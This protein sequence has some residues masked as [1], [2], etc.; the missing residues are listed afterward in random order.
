ME[1]REQF[2]T[3][4]DVQQLKHISFSREQIAGLLRVIALYQHGVY[5]E[6]E[7]SHKDRG[8]SSGSTSRVVCKA[9]SRSPC[10]GI[11]AP[12]L[13]SYGCMDRPTT[14]RLS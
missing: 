7:P 5:H 12:E 4:A 1:L 13:I 14:E 10:V 3:R 8:L 11:A 2:P 9:K 6:D